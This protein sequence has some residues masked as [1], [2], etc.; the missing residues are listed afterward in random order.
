MSIVL[1]TGRPGSGKTYTMTHHL[2]KKLNRGVIVYSNYLIE[3]NGTR[4]YPKTNLRPWSAIKEWENMTN[5]IIACDEGQRYLN[6]RKWESL[7]EQ[8]QLK[9]SQHRKDAV[10]LFLTSQHINRLDII[11]RELVDFWFNCEMWWR[12]E[13]VFKRGRNWF[14][15]L[16]EYDPDT[17]IKQYKLLPPLSKKI[18][19][20]T[21]RRARRYDTLQKIIPK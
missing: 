1:Y 16:R 5:C 9:L 12:G 7:S 8:T 20:F 18:I 10:H 21:K 19:W 17:D 3:W 14:I 4:K 2:I 15:I 6:S 13:S 11:A